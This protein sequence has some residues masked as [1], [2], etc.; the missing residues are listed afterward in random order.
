[1]TIQGGSST[2]AVAPPRVRRPH[3]QLEQMQRT[4]YLFRRNTLALAGFA[5]LLI[6][7]LVAI[8]AV[9]L[10][11]GWYSMPS[12][13]AAD[14]GPANAESGY[15]H[16]FNISSLPNCGPHLV[17]TYEVKPPP[18]A[19]AVCN[20]RWYKTP[21]VAFSNASYEY[22]VPPTAT[23]H[24][25]WEGPLPL[26]SISPLGGTFFSIYG[27]LLRGSDW[28]LIFSVTIVGIG[29]FLGLLV[30][31]VA[32]YLGGVVDDVLMRLVDI[33][34]SIPTI[35]FVVV[36]VAVGSTAITHLG[37]LSGSQTKLALLIIGFA[38]VWWPYY[39]RIVRGQ[40]LVI[41]EQRYI[42]AARA[43]GASKGRI[44]FR[45]IIP[46]SVYPIFIQFS[47]DVG[48][49]PLLIGAL[50]YL[51]FGPSLFPGSGISQ[52][53]PEWGSLA[54]ASVGNIVNILGTCVDQTGCLIPWWQFLFPGLALFFFAISV[55]LLSDGL[56][57]AL[58][59]R[60]RR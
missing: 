19:N 2:V 3:P 11:L 53:F 47:L 49:I 39:A 38:I 34:L 33:F 59:P 8:Y 13:C 51:G 30:G 24:P 57:D 46:N 1:M 48:T 28:S 60:L 40:V 20:G 58:D 14:Y 18:N 29:A 17:C 43:S 25:F 10:P 16:N 32:G 31:S 21:Y 5:I 27:G 41:R 50:V 26:G 4:W 55:N 23:I 52:P 36:V 54:A 56:R 42:E 44:L 22:Y 6:I 35:L 37:S 7:A 45:H 12:Y 15:P 9:T